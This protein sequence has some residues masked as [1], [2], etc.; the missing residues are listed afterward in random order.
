MQPEA[1]EMLSVTRPVNF[2]ASKRPRRQ[3]FKVG[4]SLL[5]PQ[6]LTLELFRLVGFFRS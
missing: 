6:L 4:A 3:D 5:F 2:D 1:E